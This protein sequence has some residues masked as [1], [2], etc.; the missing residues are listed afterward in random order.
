MEISNETI[1]DRGQIFT[2]FVD[3]LEFQE[4]I[5]YLTEWH[6]ALKKAESE[7]KNV[8]EALKWVEENLETLKSQQK[9]ATDAVNEYNDVLSQLYAM[10]GFADT[11]SSSLQAIADT[12]DIEGPKK[13]IEEIQAINTEF[14]NGTLNIEQ[15]FNKI[16]E[17]IGQINLQA[18]GEELE[19]YQ[20]I[21]AETTKSLAE[22]LEGLISGLESGSINFADYSQ[23]VKE[24]ADNMLALKIEQNDLELVDGVW[25]DA[26]GNV[27]EYAN[28]LQNAINEMSKMGDLLTTIGDNYD[29]IAE[30][31]NA[32]GQAMFEQTEV[33]TQAYTNLAN[34][35]AASLNKMK[36]SNST[37]Y[38]AIVDEIYAAM[39]DAANESV[40]ASTFITEA[41]NGNAQA[42]NAALNASAAQVATSTSK[43]TTSMGK[44]LSEL[45]KAISEF[46]Y[47]IIAQPYIEGLFNLE[48]DE[49]GIP[50]RLN[51]PKF[52]YD[53][54]GTGGDSIKNLGTALDTFG[55]DL[56]EYGSNKFTYTQLKSK[57]KPYVPSGTGKT[58][59]PSTPSS[60]KGSGGGSSSTDK[61][62]YYA[63]KEAEEA[64]RA[65]EK[66]Y[67]ESVD[68]FEDSIEEREKLEERWV[69]RQEQLG[70]L[71]N[72]DYLYITQQRIERYKKYLKEVE[73]ATW[74]SEEDKLRLMTEY[75]EKIQDLEVDYLGYLEDQLNDEIEAIEEANKEKI[76]LIE[77]EADAK[78]AALKKVEDERDRE[79]ETEDY[80]KERQ[81]ILDE[82]AYWEQRT[83]REAQENLAR[84]RKD[85]EEL[86]AEWEDIQEDWAT[87]DQIAEIEA[88]RDAE[89]AAIEEAEKKEIEALKAIYDAKVKMYVETGDL[90]YEESV[91]QS[92]SLYNAYKKNFIDPVSQELENLSKKA[93]SNITAAGTTTATTSQTTEQQ[94]ETY[95]IKSG[96]TLSK[97]AKKY[98]TTVEKLMAANPY[99]TN[100]NKIFAG[101]TLQI[102]KFHEGGIVGGN[103][104]AFA[105]LKPHEVILKPEWADGINRL[106]KMAKAN[107]GPI[108]N[109]TVV[110][111][112]G[113]LV[114][115]DAKIN[116]KT[117]AEY[118]TRR[119]EKM[120]KDKFNIK[121]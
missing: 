47:N 23:G 111:V 44:V 103:Q 94:F 72:E 35:V 28:S 13:L 40:N 97:I 2:N 76:K 34:S 50:K 22:G 116:D 85:L 20:A 5:K 92:E 81:S 52:G 69:K 53:I 39:G 65:R 74:L 73:N 91:I 64:E 61:S 101:K 87:E 4:Q 15:Y 95:T 7:G 88:R 98:G 55:A 84:A 3:K 57:Q 62:D 119:V 14:S 66:A 37:A 24:A 78:I 26:A 8:G 32:A 46:K 54:T 113:D 112:K 42:L 99:I 12:Y 17:K 75:S 67:K 58:N 9:Q 16:E 80:Q 18:E 1:R 102:P 49:N 25:Q 45:G 93:A 104:E 59:N 96:D 105:L 77:E 43:V 86:D 10:L 19:A 48:K 115:I 29:Y 27:D 41:L 89:I 21:F 30:H 56:T 11:L 110:E 31:A 33:G 109:S 121:K 60:P 51:L 100:K 117:D 106:A 6:Y 120:L 83:G 68:A 108:N 71:S 79:R 114:R 82:I 90:I 63:K 38:Q 118:L 36:E 107:E 70:Q